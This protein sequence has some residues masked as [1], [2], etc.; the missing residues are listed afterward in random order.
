MKR[1]H[2]ETLGVETDAT[3]EDIK[4]AY[5]QKAKELHPDKN[6]GDDR[7]FVALNRANEV[8][9]DDEKRKRYDE[10]GEDGTDNDHRQVMAILTNFSLIFLDHTKDVKKQSLTDFVRERI[11]E[12]IQLATDLMENIKSD[13]SKTNDVLSRLKLAKT[14]EED[15]LYMVFKNRILSGE[16]QVIEHEKVC[17][18]MKIALEEL[19]NYSYLVDNSNGQTNRYA[20]NQ[21]GFDRMLNNLPP[22]FK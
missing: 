8:L 3:Q 17:N 18:L 19:K 12:A 13:I 21:S 20:M 4:K 7:G 2:Y 22:W 11:N 5:R 10:T 14:T 6:D 1:P 9:S 15:V 16:E